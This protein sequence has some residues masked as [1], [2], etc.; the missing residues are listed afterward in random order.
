MLPDQFRQNLGYFNWLFNPFHGLDASGIYDLLSTSSPTEFGLYLNLGYW[1]EAENTDEASDALAMSVANTAQISSEDTVLD[2]GFGFG[3]QDILWMQTLKPKQI[4]GL[5]ITASQVTIARK[6]I[7]VAGLDDRIDLR[8]GSATEMPIASESVDRVVALESAFHF[9]T[10]ERFFREAW[11]VLRSG[12]RL[13]TA[14]IIP[15]PVVS[16]LRARL[17]QRVSWGLVAR[18]FAIP[19]ENA[20]T[21]PIYHSTLATCGYEEI[22]VESIRDHVYAP[23]HQY[24]VE[25]PERLE[26]LHPMARLAARM[27]L[28]YEAASVYAG[29]DYVLATAVKPSSPLS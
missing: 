13:V 23:L 2:C 5:N 27:A 8:H 3:D 11:R 12:G 4:I 18:K 7:A 21:R 29:L 26:R 22:Q 6:R 25:H 17:K 16:P 10:R 9:H 14:D 24:L 20:Y 28:R 1:C 19:I 15:M